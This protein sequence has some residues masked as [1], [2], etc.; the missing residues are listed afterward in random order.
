MIKAV[1]DIEEGDSFGSDWV[2]LGPAVQTGIGW[3][4]VP[5]R[6]RDGARGMREWTDPK[7]SIIVNVD[8]D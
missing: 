6:Y 7:T 3:I 2:A 4:V 1:K 8:G 5:V